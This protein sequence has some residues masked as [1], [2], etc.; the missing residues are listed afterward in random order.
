MRSAGLHC[1]ALVWPWQGPLGAS[2]GGQFQD[3]DMVLACLEAASIAAGAGGDVVRPPY[4]MS[5]WVAGKWNGPH[6][7]G[8]NCLYSPSCLELGPAWE[9][10][11]KDC[12]EGRREG[13]PTPRPADRKLWLP[14]PPSLKAWIPGFFHWPGRGKM[15]TQDP[16]AAGLAL[17]GLGK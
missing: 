13:A 4:V 16:S 2:Q 6:G 3:V 8:E 5:L 10:S 15:G 11:W 17:G 9:G 1:E 14:A 7:S 12:L